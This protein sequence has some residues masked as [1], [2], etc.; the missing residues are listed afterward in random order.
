MHIHVHRTD[1]AHDSIFIDPFRS[2]HLS[3][4]GAVGKIDHREDVLVGQCSSDEIKTVQVICEGR[5]A[6]CL[7]ICIHALRDD[8][9]RSK[10]AALHVLPRLCESVIFDD[11]SELCRIQLPGEVPGQCRVVIVHDTYRQVVRQ[12][13]FQKGQEE[14]GAEGHSHH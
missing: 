6:A 14:D 9:D 12:S 10:L 13:V 1:S 3:L 5:S 2:E 11:L 8:A 4:D 7:H